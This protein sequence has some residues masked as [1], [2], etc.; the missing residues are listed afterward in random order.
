MVKIVLAEVI[1]GEVGDVCSLHVG[2]I[3][4]A[5]ETDVHG[6]GRYCNGRLE[7]SK[8]GYVWGLGCVWEGGVKPNL[9][10]ITW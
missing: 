10:S 1:L 7:A 9:F 3:G 8:S 6:Y 2:D 5:E 4:G